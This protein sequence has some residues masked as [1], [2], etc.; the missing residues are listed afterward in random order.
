VWVQ[1]SLPGENLT[2]KWKVMDA[3]GRVL[4]NGQQW[5]ES[6]QAKM[7]VIDWDGRSSSGADL[8][9]GIYFYQVLLLTEDGLEAKVGGKFM[10]AQ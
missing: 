7:T 4:A 9:G 10:K 5:Q 2:V 6:A 8:Q 3:S 1:H